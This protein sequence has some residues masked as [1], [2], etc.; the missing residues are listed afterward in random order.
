MNVNYE[1]RSDEPEGVPMECF[2]CGGPILADMGEIAVDG[3]MMQLHRFC[4][5]EFK[6][7]N[8]ETF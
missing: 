2:W 8:E 7:A 3:I 6:A 4:L 5:K 1:V